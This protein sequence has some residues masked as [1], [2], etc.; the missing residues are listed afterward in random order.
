MK[1]KS[2]STKHQPTQREMREEER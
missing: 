2:L 1:T